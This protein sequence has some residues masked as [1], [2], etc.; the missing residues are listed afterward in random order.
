MNKEVDVGQVWKHK[1]SKYF[2]DS[3]G[4]LKHCDLWVD[5][6]TY[7][8]VDNGKT[9]TRGLNDFLAKFERVQS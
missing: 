9:Y 1:E 7:R 2:I 4:Q 6:V 3:I 5:C 8:D